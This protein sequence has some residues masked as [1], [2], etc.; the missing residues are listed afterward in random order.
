MLKLETDGK[1]QEYE[2]LHHQLV[3]NLD[4]KIQECQSL[5]AAVKP[6]TPQQNSSA[7]TDIPTQYLSAKLVN[8]KHL[9]AYITCK[10][11]Y[12]TIGMPIRISKPS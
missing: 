11:T 1:L 5:E 8:C 10:K 6:G 4:V 12:T 3:E 7:Q 2:E 9:T